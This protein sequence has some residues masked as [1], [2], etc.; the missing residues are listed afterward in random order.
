MSASKKVSSASR[1]VQKMNAPDPKRLDDCMFFKRLGF[2]LSEE[3]KKFRDAIYD[4]NIS[5]VICNARAGSG[6]AQPKDTLIPTPNGE[7]KLGELNVGDYV[8]GRDGKPT[9]VLGVFDQGL[10]E[11]YRITFSDGR[12]TI[13]NGE[14]LWT[15]YS[16]TTHFLVTETLNSMLQRQVYTGRNKTPRYSV[17]LCDSVEYCEK[18]YEIDPYVVG[19]F[20]GDGSCLAKRLTVSSSDEELV[21]TV[22]EICDFGSYQRVHEKNYDWIFA[23]KDGKRVNTKDFFAN[24]P[25]L[26]GHS[27]EKRIPEQYFYGSVEQRFSLLQGLMDTDGGIDY[28]QCRYNV[29]FST[30]N[31]GLKDDI[32]RLIRGL[33]Y[34]VSVTEDRRLNKYPNTGVCYN[35]YFKI[36][37]D[38]KT[39]LFRLSRKKEKAIQAKA[40][41]KRRKYDRIGI[42]GVERL[43]DKYDMRCIYVDNPEHLYLTNDF[44]VTHNTTLAVATACLMVECG[45][46]DDIFYCFSTNNG[47]R[48]SLGFLPGSAEEKEASFYEPCLQALVACGYQPEKCVRELSPE[49]E[50][51]GMAFVSCRSHAFLRGTN[52]GD[53]TILILDETQNCYWDEIKKILTR[54][55]DGAKVVMIGHI[56]QVDI[57]KH[58]ENSGFKAYINLFKDDPYVKVCQL[59]K[60]FRGHISEVA[61]TMTAETFRKY[62][63]M[64]LPFSEEKISE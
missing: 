49:G 50:K 51:S 45:L 38:V 55:K 61:D 7:K 43:P 4:P 44:I 29:R 57:Q 62:R 39:N 48:E 12:T 58:P 59:T 21:R 15:Y 27:Y 40:T 47:A 3:Q 14:H 64:E 53:R 54:V 42:V 23:Y 46:Y 34:T 5:M 25:E 37:N 60:N 8:F 24:V 9:R 16:D 56:G 28:A 17:P 11:A 32:V 20:L 26:I 6:K 13:C 18:K 41:D 36:P 30:V 63:E 33:G 1:E 19:V 2:E 22:S 31:G 35:I 10:L 52:I